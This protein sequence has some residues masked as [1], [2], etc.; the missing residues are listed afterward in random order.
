MEFRVQARSSECAARVAT[1]ETPHGT[2]ETPSFMPVGTQ[3][4]VKAMTS[5]ELRRIGTQILLGNTYHLY[6]RPGHEVIREAGGLH[7]FMNWDGPILTDSGGFQ[8]YSL[9]ALRKITDDGV[10]FQSHLDGS[11][12]C[13]TPRLC[14]EIQGAL[15]SD[16]IMALDECPPHPSPREHLEQA[17]E[18]TICWARKCQSAVTRDDQALF[19]ISQG[20]TDPGLRSK[21]NEKLVEMDFPGYAIG[22]LAVGETPEKRFETIE[23]VV[24]ELPENKPRY[25]MG[26]GPPEEIFEIVE[27]GIDLFDCVMP[28]RNARNGS[29]FTHFGPVSIKQARYERDFRPLDGDCQCE[30]C[31]EYTRAYLRHLFKSNE[32][33]G[34][35][36]NTLHNLFFV[37]E[38]CAQIRDAIQRDRFLQF[39]DEFLERYRSNP[40]D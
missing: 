28:T 32:I 17:V 29:L 36:L 37:L 8:V 25:L 12:H 9:A 10:E 4:S 21:C 34:I 16:I 30:T 2:I 5:A 33:L 39:K 13:L 7:G 31:R 38:L 1:L 14:M 6:L 11:L 26:S 35:R 18:R 24:P 23:Y 15:G 19:A 40:V 20:G 27:R 22:G 3:G